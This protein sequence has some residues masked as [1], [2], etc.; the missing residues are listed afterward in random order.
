MSFPHD[1]HHPPREFRDLTIAENNL[2]GG[3]DF[4]RQPPPFFRAT[5]QIVN[6]QRV[7]DCKEDD[8]PLFVPGYA[9]AHWLLSS[10]PSLAIHC[11]PITASRPRP[12]AAAATCSAA[13]CSFRRWGFC[14]ATPVRG[15]R[16][17][18]RC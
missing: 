18:R 6:R 16:V 7:A 15:S 8:R 3:A 2:H 5:F 14:T 12:A 11:P 17:R 9:L 1:G 10:Y 13:L 4:G